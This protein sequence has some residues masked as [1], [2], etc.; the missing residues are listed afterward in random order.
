MRSASR[1]GAGGMA[2]GSGKYRRKKGAAYSK[3]EE[4][5]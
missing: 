4:D 2:Q 3:F 1:D 5:F